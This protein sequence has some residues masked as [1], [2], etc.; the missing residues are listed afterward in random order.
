MYFIITISEKPNAP[1]TTIMISAAAVIMPPVC[2]VPA[3]MDSS[4]EAPRRRASTIR[5]TKKTS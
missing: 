2:A 1:E 4:V 5:E 3:A